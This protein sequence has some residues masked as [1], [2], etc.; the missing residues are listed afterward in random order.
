LTFDI[1]QY[2]GGHRLESQFIGYNSV[3]TAVKSSGVAMGRR[4][5]IAS[6]PSKENRVK[7]KAQM[8]QK[9][10]SLRWL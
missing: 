6:I 5:N 2:G 3:V 10:R 7:G 4:H 1:I 8:E 9:F